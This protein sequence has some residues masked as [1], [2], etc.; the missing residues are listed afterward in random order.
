[1]LKRILALTLLLLGAQAMADDL[2]YS[3]IEG[4]Y[5]RI[6]VDTGA[7]FGNV[8][9]DGIGIGFSF[10]VADNWYILGAYGRAS[11]DF[12]VDFDETELG[13]GYHAPLAD[14]LDI[15]ATVSYLRAEFS[16]TVFGSFDDDG[17]GIAVGMRGL[18]ADRFDLTGSIGYSDF[19][20]GSDGTAFS[21]AGLYNFT[22]N[23]AA[24]IVLAF[25]EDVTTYGIGARYYLGR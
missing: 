4:G 17:Y 24:G 19:G 6:D 7:G 16:D 8:D 18:V 13:V 15:F 2:G 20:G 3:Y 9:G 25:D 14:R 21:A 23:F 12:G 1:M 5:Q 22:D 11:L 10:D